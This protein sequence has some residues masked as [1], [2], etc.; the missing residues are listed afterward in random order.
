VQNYQTWNALP[1]GHICQI[2]AAAF[3][4]QNKNTINKLTCFTLFS[5]GEV[6]PVDIVYKEGSDRK[7]L[8]EIQNT[9]EYCNV[10]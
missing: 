9:A 1:F 2:P 6:D 3:C 8:G 4:N 10:I 5:I 7:F